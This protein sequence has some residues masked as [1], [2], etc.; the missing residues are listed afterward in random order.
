MTVDERKANMEGMEHVEHAECVEHVEHVG[1]VERGETLEAPE[2]AGGAGGAQAA[3]AAERAGGA[4]MDRREFVG[5]SA[6]ALASAA[7]LSSPLLAGAEEAASE[8]AAGAADATEAGLPEVG[9]VIEGFK[10]VSHYYIG[11]LDVTCVR[12]EHEKT[13]AT[14]L[15]LPCEDTNRAFTIGFRTPTYDD[16]GIPHVFE[17]ST[18][19]G[20]DKYPNPSL[21]FAMTAQTY[22]TYLNA[23]TY[24]YC[25]MYPAASLSE[26]QLYVYT[27][28]L[29]SG[30]FHPT[31]MTDERPMMREAYRYELA[32]RDADITLAGTVYSEM[33]G[34]LTMESRGLYDLAKLLYPGSYLSSITGGDPDVI[35][36]MTHQDLIDFHNERY[37]PSNCLIT[38]YG[39]LDLE[40]FLKLV[41]GGYPSAFEKRDIPVEDPFYQPTEGFL[42]GTSVWP[43]AEGTQTT[44]AM[45]YAISLDGVGDMDRT[46]A[47]GFLGAFQ[48]DGSPLSRLS[49]ERLPGAMIQVSIESDIMKVPSLLF[50]CTGAQAEDLDT[51]KQVVDDALAATL[52]QGVSA[53]AMKAQCQQLRFQMGLMRESGD[54]GVNLCTMLIA[55]WGNTGDPDAYRVLVDSLDEYEAYAERD[56]LTAF[57]RERLAESKRSG[58]LMIVPEAGGLERRDAETK[59]MLA[60][61]KASMTDE[62]IDALVARTEDFAQWTAENEQATGIEAVKVVDV[63]SL[64]EEASVYTAESEVTDGVKY[65]TCE[66]ESDDLVFV[67]LDFDTS[68]IPFDRLFDYGLAAAMAGSMA[69]ASHAADEVA[70]L[71]SQLFYGFAVSAG[72]IS[73]K[74]GSYRPSCS[75]QGMILKDQVDEAFDLIEEILLE[76]DFSDVDRFRNKLSENDLMFRMLG[77]LMPSSF[78]GAL[79]G[80]LV[81]ESGRYADQVGGFA[82]MRRQNALMGA[83]DEELED[84]VLRVQEMWGQVPRRDGLIFSCVGTADGIAAARARFDE[85]TGRL[86]EVGRTPVDYSEQL[87]ELEAPVALEVPGTL[88]YNYQLLPMLKNGIENNGRLLAVQNLVGDAILMPILRFQN[89]AYGAFCQLN[90]DFI[91]AVS[92]R[93]PEYEKTF[94]VYAQ[95][96][97]LLRG[98]ELTQDDLDGYITSAFSSLAM[99]IGP[100][101]GGSTAVDD[102]VT[103]R[104]TFDDNL[105]YMGELKRF[106]LD[107][108]PEC[109]AVFDRL[110]EEGVRFS[111]GSAQVIEEHQNDFGTIIRDLVE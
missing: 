45:Y 20:S 103:G 24:P 37:H 82:Y 39:K 9:S 99:P 77:S 101:T 66:V 90:D 27:D 52:E 110:A 74:D 36:T 96:G 44:P 62:E 29:L 38:L 100:L 76:T 16:K 56:G 49:D 89:S 87:P 70:S 21:F 35:P 93:D 91:A 102:A 19:C 11:Y 111:I 3:D 28:Y 18:L 71:T 98:L 92:Y 42:E 83:S 10:V 88:M 41:D 43:T 95:L 57:L 85:F 61:M 109:T 64:P 86:E 104:T 55:S 46:L 40:R 60:D 32:D 14:L 26:D 6:A 23:M 50:V 58:L 72:Y 75:V 47:D 22:N 68:F 4:N 15:Y 31:I 97:D 17:H 1:C 80:P 106:T 107:D 65:V 63:A 54:V 8:G 48:V 84:A 94:D 25:T 34:A 13:G 79:I 67:K 12:M 5:L 30:V 108:L 78:A 73:Y 69:T 53:D 105:R 51:F 81:Y 7:A 33:L 59:Q 2:R